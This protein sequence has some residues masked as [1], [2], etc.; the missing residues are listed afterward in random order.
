MTIRQSEIA[1]DLDELRDVV[2]TLFE[3]GAAT[4]K[5][6]KTRGGTWEIEATKA[7]TAQQAQPLRV[8]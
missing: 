4:V 2:V 6:R 1:P 5:A 8:R 7:T 3:A